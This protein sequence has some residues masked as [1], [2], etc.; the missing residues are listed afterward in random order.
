MYGY[1]RPLKPE[2]RIR[3]FELYNAAYCGLC[4]TLGRE[5]GLLARFAVNYDCTLPVLMSSPAEAALCKK[6]CPA[7]FGRKK[8]CL[9]GGGG[10]DMTA[11][12]AVILA[13]HKLLDTVS[14]GGFFKRLSARVVLG[15]SGRKFRRAASRWP[16][17]AE[18]A[19][20]HLSELSRIESSG[21]SSPDIL[22]RAADCF[23]RVTAGFAQMAPD[24]PT[25][26]IWHEVYYH[27][28]RAVYILDAADDWGT[29]V[30]NG[31]FNP[32]V[33]RYGLELSPGDDPR[34]ALIP[35]DARKKIS[36]TIENSLS[37]AAAAF[38][39]LP[40][41][42]FSGIVGN[43]IYLGIPNMAGAV[44]NR[45]MRANKTRGKKNGS[46]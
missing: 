35:D 46:L 28:G 15:I 43:I 22:D 26:R 5:Y 19:E 1:I 3:E 20:K 17:F 34:N 45:T 36:E 21:D 32:A 8:S 6:R 9:C 11:A 40:S 30:R 16:E 7:R 18:N 10:L 2:L 4:H 38:E 33:I 14:D 39:L 29:D 27:I 12:A 42:E 37:L 31:N 25:G 41:G 23:A 44:L 13:R 24:K